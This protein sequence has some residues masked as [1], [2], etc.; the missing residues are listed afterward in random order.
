MMEDHMPP[1]TPQELVSQMKAQ[2]QQFLAA[3]DALSTERA[4][5]PGIC[6][7]WSAKAVVDHLTGWQVQSLPIVR[8]L[9]SSEKGDFDVDID[10]FNRMSVETREDLSWDESL[11]A[12]KESY[13]AFDEALHDLPA[14]RT[15]T[16][17][18]LKSWLQA[19]IHE[20]CFHLQHIESTQCP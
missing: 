10:A 20:Y 11:E 5:A 12:F 6:G 13:E 8:Q 9:L 17:A 1:P 3:C 18:G 19:M 7:E 2:Y 16:N 14:A 4:L 15:R